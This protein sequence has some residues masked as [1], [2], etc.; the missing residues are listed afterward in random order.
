[1][2]F[3]ITFKIWKIRVSFE[4]A[5]WPKEKGRESRPPLDLAGIA[6]I[7]KSYERT[8]HLHMGR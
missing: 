2:S 1:M 6:K 5:L 4:I 3:R 7:A 8:A